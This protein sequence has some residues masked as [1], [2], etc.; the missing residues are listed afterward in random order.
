MDE[1]TNTEA[2]TVEGT[3]YV[4]ACSD[5]EGV[6]PACAPLAN[7]YVPFQQE[8]AAKYDARRGLIR[9]TL[10]PGLDLP[11]MGRVNKK[12]Q[13][14]TPQHQMQALHFAI[15]ELALY[16]DTHPTDAEALDLMRQY[17]ALSEQVKAAL[18]AQYGPQTV[19]N[20]GQ[21]GTYNW[22]ESPWPWELA[23]NEEA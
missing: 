15:H 20:A 6:L 10:F 1:A 17:V 4:K 11:F 14:D 19:M 21:N 23:A 22:I 16:L 2:K 9:G 3:E 18:E 8:G 7:P 5:A 13:P 12:E